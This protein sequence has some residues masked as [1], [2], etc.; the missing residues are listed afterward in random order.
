[1]FAL[2][3]RLV[4]AQVFFIGSSAEIYV[5]LRFLRCARYT[6]TLVLCVEPPPPP[7]CFYCRHCT[8]A[9]EGCQDE[10]VCFVNSLLNTILNTVG[11][12]IFNIV[13]SALESLFYSFM[14]R[15]HW[16]TT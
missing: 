13:K 7:I 8:R 16:Y 3:S 5:I 6:I 12:Q 4:T 11:Q 1:M 10:I 14:L 2:H 9:S 15:Y